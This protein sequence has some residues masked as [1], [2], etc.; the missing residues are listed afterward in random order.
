MTVWVTFY[1]TCD[2]FGTNPNGG[3]FLTMR[4]DGTALRQL[5]AT[6]GVTRD[7]DGRIR[8]ASGVLTQRCVRCALSENRRYGKPGFYSRYLRHR[9]RQ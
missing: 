3:Q 2:P 6:R 5:T 4:P 9:R 7:P 8:A 1:S